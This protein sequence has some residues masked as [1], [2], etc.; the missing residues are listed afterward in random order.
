[1]V[2]VL[3][4]QFSMLEIAVAFVSVVSLHLGV[5]FSLLL[6]ALTFLASAT[7]QPSRSCVPLV[8]GEDTSCTEQSNLP[9]VPYGC[10]FFFGSY[11]SKQ[12]SFSKRTRPP[13]LAVN[14]PIG[15]FCLLFML[16]HFRWRGGGHSLRVFLLTMY[17]S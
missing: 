10:P 8:C 14:H 9:W 16:A 15:F 4:S 13:F 1:M 5:F 2:T 3:N 7:G 12:A 17:S 6:Y 11:S